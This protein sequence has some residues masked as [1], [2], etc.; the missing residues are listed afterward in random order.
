[1]GPDGLVHPLW[2]SPDNALFVL[3]SMDPFVL[4][5]V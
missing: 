1:M 5:S 4:L 2:I 3:V